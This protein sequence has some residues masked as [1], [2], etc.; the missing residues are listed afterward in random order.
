MMELSDSSA[1]KLVL[2]FDG[3][4]NRYAKRLVR[5]YSH[6][7]NVVFLGLVPHAT[8]QGMYKSC[9]VVVFPS[10][11]ETWGLPISEAKK[12]GKIVL[13]ADLPYAHESVGDYDYAE[14]FHPDDFV[15]L[16][17]LVSNIAAGNMTF[18]PHIIGESVRPDCVGWLALVRAILGHR[19]D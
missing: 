12:F 13:A 5:R 14:F 11:L 4:E 17:R 3:S 16:L 8:V 7:R 9:D 15:G 6:L 10:K 18:R 19:V 2:T 1:L